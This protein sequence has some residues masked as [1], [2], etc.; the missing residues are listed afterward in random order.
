M[1]DYILENNLIPI[2]ANQVGQHTTYCI[3]ISIAI[4]ES[5]NVLLLLLYLF[6][7]IMLIFHNV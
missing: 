3:Y 6:Y 7:Q 4:L 1:L 2:E 5:Q